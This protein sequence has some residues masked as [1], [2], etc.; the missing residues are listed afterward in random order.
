MQYNKTTKKTKNALS[1]YPTD[2]MKNIY[3]NEIEKYIVSTKYN[4]TIE[5]LTKYYNN[6]FNTQISNNT[7]YRIIKEV[8]DLEYKNLRI[9]T[10][11]LSTNNYIHEKYIFL[12]FML[13][14]M[15]KNFNIIFIDESCF[16]FRYSKRKTWKKKNEKDFKNFEFGNKDIDNYQL[17]IAA[18]FDKIY[19]YELWQGYN[20]RFT[21]RDFLSNLIRKVE[22]ANTYLYMDNATPHINAEIYN[23]IVEKKIKVIYG[24]NN[25]SNL[26]FIEYLFR[27]VKIYHYKESYTSE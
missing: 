2:F 27:C 7:F 8:F 11:Y 22:L 21:Y 23:F 14:M 24:I 15:M 6:K 13:K 20:N 3:F 25:F 1:V 5:S 18:S 16:S 17:I 9:N 19:Y 4:F 12:K 10:N 26:D